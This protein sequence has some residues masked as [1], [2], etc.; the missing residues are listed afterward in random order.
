MSEENNDD[1]IMMAASTMGQDLIGLFI[2]EFRAM[3]DVW[4]KLPQHKQD[5][6]IERVRLRIQKNVKEAA[7]IINSQGNVVIK[8][9]LLK[10]SIANGIETN[11]RILNTDNP[12]ISELLELRKGEDVSLLLSHADQFLGGIEEITGDDDQTDWVDD[13]ETTSTS[14]KTLGEILEGNKKDPLYDE[15]VKHIQKTGNDTIQSIM[16]RFNIDED[17]SE[18]LLVAIRDNGDIVNS[19][20]EEMP[21]E[22]DLDIPSDETV[23]E[24]L[25]ESGNFE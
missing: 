3:P 6:V 14:G 18:A 16:N 25:E 24:I 1:L 19:I 11:V 13:S 7:R 12:N 9:Q 17:R 22:Q 20:P 10:T 15:A 5:E 23:Q 2:Q 21:N 4:Q 8:A